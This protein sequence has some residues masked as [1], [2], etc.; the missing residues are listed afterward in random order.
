[1]AKIV[2]KY[3]PLGAM[4]LL[5]AAFMV[6]CSYD[7]EIPVTKGVVLPGTDGIDGLEGL[8]ISGLTSGVWG[9]EKL[10]E[11]C[12][13]SNIS[14]FLETVE[15]P[16]SISN[17]LAIIKINDVLIS[18]IA[19]N[20]TQ[21]DFNTIKTL[22]LDIKGD[23]TNVASFPAHDAN[24]LGESVNLKAK[25]PLSL[26]KQKADCLE[27]YVSLEGTMPKEDVIFDLVTKAT[28]KYSISLF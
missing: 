22:S 21:G 27:F 23:G 15:L 10:G 11:I 28:I 1:M 8:D 18:E 7:I 9:P 16:S 20:A 17:I 3:L 19:F 14:E 5:T 25:K 2:T 6:G 4:L 13:L 26:L 24:G 12:G